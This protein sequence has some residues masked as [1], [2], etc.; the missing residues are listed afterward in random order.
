MK[1][2]KSRLNIPGFS[3]GLKTGEW[4]DVPK[5][6]GG[7]PNPKKSGKPHSIDELIK[8]KGI[9][10]RKWKTA[11][12]FSKI[13]QKDYS[14]RK[15]IRT[16]AAHAPTT[17]NTLPPPCNRRFFEWMGDKAGWMDYTEQPELFVSKAKVAYEVTDGL[18]PM[19]STTSAREALIVCSTLARYGI[20]A[21]FNRVVIR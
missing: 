12:L 3:Y 21:H 4:I 7:R 15:R 18:L 16:R 1:S 8:S 6:Y 5:L 11:A 2:N 20:A 13:S 9:V 10:S 19:L 17:N 14:K